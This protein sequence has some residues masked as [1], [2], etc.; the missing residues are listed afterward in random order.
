[1]RNDFFKNYIY[2]IAMMSGSI[3]G[4]G[5]L[6]LPYIT[7]RVG[8]FTML[9]YFAVLTSLMIF[10]HVI[11]GKISLKTPDF[12][13][14][15]GF[16]GYYLGDFAKKTTLVLT[17][18][19]LFGVLLAYL[20]VGGRFLE[21]VF[22]PVFG[23]SNFFYTALYFLA[24]GTVIYFGLRVVSRIEFWAL[25]FL[26]AILVI[27]FLKSFSSISFQNIFLNSLP[28]IKNFKTMFLPYGA[29]LFSLWGMGLIPEVEEMLKGRKHTL[30]K[31]IIIST[32]IPAVFYFLFI[33]LIL[34][35]TGSSTTDSALV[36]L[37]NFFGNGLSS[38]ALL[39]GVATTFAAFTAHGLVLKKM[40][41]Y[42]AGLKEHQAW[43]LACFV[44]LILFLIGLN[45]FIPLISFIGSVFLGIN[46]IFIL[47]IY[48][49]IGGKK[50]VIYPLSLIFILGIVY[51]I[52]YFIKF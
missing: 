12:K 8:I 11:F 23:Q 18:F 14:F 28:V 46:G 43:A 26:L 20:I 35:V 21:A 34:G 51:E 38:V 48:K 27:V 13:R 15:P 40:L 6:S 2:P 17:V 19:G 39:I 9:F 44:P 4:V 3:I 33:L 41:V 52:I 22:S 25:I 32:L 24:A 37:K 49:K 30:K 50:W 5:F 29:I 10:L 31:I 16:V 7:L 42:D 47:L 1:M 45:A 36:G